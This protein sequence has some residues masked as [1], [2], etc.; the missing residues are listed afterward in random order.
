MVCY[1]LQADLKRPHSIG[2]L[3]FPRSV[4][5]QHANLMQL[6]SGPIRDSMPGF[7]WH[8]IPAEILIGLTGKYPGYTDW[9]D[10]YTA[11]CMLILLQIVRGCLYHIRTA[12]TI[13]L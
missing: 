7:H 4:C 10:T 6:A 5:L 1:K 13:S 9:M 3:M 12:G 11:A 2:H 8:F